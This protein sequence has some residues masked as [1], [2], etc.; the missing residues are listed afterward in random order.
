MLNKQ[1]GDVFEQ[2]NTGDSLVPWIGVGEV[3]ADVAQGS[4]TKQRVTDGVKE[5]VGVGVAFE[6]QR[7]GNLYSTKD[8]LSLCY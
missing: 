5:N 3:F 7:M 1:V 6:S 8:E 4:G 2:K